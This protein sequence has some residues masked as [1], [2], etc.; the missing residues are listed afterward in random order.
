MNP[1]GVWRPAQGPRGQNTQGLLHKRPG[2]QLP[3]DQERAFWREKIDPE[4]Q[5]SASG[6][7]A[8]E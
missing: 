5:G 7:H 8:A 6:Q 1:L 3:L 4:A 2:I